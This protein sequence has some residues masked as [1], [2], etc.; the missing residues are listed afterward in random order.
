MFTALSAGA[1][2]QAAALERSARGGEWDLWLFS[3]RNAIFLAVPFAL[4]GAR[5]AFLVVLLAYAA[6]S[7]FLLQ[8][9]RRIVP[10]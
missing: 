3:R 8:R 4:L 5:T 10:S 6:I 7:F 1:F 9:L 2:A